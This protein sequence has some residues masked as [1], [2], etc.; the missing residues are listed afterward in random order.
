MHDLAW[1]TGLT[2]AALTALAFLGLNIG[3]SPAQQLIERAT[4]RTPP[5]QI[6]GYL[7]AIA[8]GDRTA[9]LARWPV[10]AQADEALQAR[11]QAVTDELLAYGP[12]LEHR[13]VAVTWWSTCC[14][15]HVIDDPGGAGGARVQVAIRSQTRLEKVYLFDLLVPGGYWGDA[16]GYPVRT[17]AIVDVYPEGEA[18]LAWMVRE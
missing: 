6:A 12:H 7:T 3:C 11:R 15:P 5:A 1:R 17:W 2:L 8:E 4:G 18:P 16:A 9:A 10:G 14:E 13:I